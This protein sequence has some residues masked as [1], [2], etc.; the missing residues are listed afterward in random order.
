MW[1]QRVRVLVLAFALV[2]A[3]GALPVPAQAQQVSAV[4]FENILREGLI[5]AHICPDSDPAEGDQCLACREDGRCSVLQGLQI[6]VNI[7][8]FLLGISGSLAFAAFILGGF[9]WVT[10][11][12]SPE[13]ITKGKNIMVSA[14]LGLGITFGSYAA[15]N[16]L[17]AAITNQAPGATLED[18]LQ[19][20]QAETT[21]VQTVPSSTD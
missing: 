15:I 10:A 16:F 9:Y 20:T 2:G 12:G 11:M 7:T 1:W 19:G 21:G 17:I 5:F 6:F 13:K 3:V 14:A 4:R 18:T 8:V